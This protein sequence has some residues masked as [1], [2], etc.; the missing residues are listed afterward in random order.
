MPRFY[1]HL[2]TAQGLK[3]DEIGLE[4]PDVETAYLEAFQTA[5]EMW[6]DLLRKREDP[7]RNTFEITDDLGHVIQTLPFAEVLD[8]TRG[9]TARRKLPHPARTAQALADR[10]RCLAAALD[11]QVRAARESIRH[12]QELLSASRS[13]QRR[14]TVPWKAHPD[15]KP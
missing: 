7:T 11:E 15:A 6:P 13:N 10:T 2:R 14:V 1:F 12:S 9:H 5:L 4:L 3:P 8:S